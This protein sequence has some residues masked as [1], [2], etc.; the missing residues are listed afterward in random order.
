M[1]KK[2]NGHVIS[3]HNNFS[4]FF[5]QKNEG[6]FSTAVSEE[7]IQKAKQKGKSIFQTEEWGAV[8]QYSPGMQEIVD[9]RALEQ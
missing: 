5:L 2:I 3:K 4:P 1:N 8:A 6:L 9:Q 7:T